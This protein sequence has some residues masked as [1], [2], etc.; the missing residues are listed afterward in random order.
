VIGRLGGLRLHG[1]DL[2]LGPCLGLGEVQALLRGAGLVGQVGRGLHHIR[3]HLERRS[4]P[5]LQRGIVAGHGMGAARQQ[6]GHDQ[7]A[8]CGQTVA[9]SM[10]HGLVS[11][12]GALCGP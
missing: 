2:V 5:H 10:L 8:E 3:E 11:P 6:C 12:Q 4:G 9:M 1:V 7:Q